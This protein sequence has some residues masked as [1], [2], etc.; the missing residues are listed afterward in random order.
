[1]EIPSYTSKPCHIIGHFDSKRHSKNNGS[2]TFLSLVEKIKVIHGYLY[3][4]KHNQNGSKLESKGMC[5]MDLECSFGVYIFMK[6]EF[7]KGWPHLHQ[8]FHKFLTLFHK[9]FIP[10]LSNS[11][12]I[13]IKINSILLH[14]HLRS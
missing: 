14:H 5:K 8:E 4:K 11:S 7:G 12:S 13:F 1:M 2:S 6:G 9:S 10:N 3:L